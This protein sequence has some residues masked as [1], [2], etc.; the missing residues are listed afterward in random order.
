MDSD[1]I[2]LA[3]PAARPPA[4]A[5]PSDM[6]DGPSGMPDDDAASDGR[7]RSRRMPEPGDT[8]VYSPHRTSAEAPAPA[9]VTPLWAT[10]TGPSPAAEPE[11]VESA[12]V[13]VDLS[14]RRR[15]VGRRAG[16]AC[17]GLLAAFLVAIG[18][19]V[20]TGASVPGTP[21]TAV[22]GTQ[23]HKKS[24]TPALQPKTIP[25]GQER[26]GG[27][28]PVAVP[29]AANGP[30]GGTANGRSPAPTGGSSPSSAPKPSSAVTPSK[31]ATPAPLP[32]RTRP[33][34][35]KATTP[36]QTKRPKNNG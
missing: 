6:P 36:G 8:L 32:T 4:P 17:G 33:G 2:S 20:A 30:N 29:P 31:T 10:P 19:G 25:H 3:D 18:V 23:H 16:I 24:R 7:T 11:D 15:R 13:F 28:P 27:N 22:P 26:P 14:G 12:P 35:G 5:G 1:T 9:P 34:N 21:W